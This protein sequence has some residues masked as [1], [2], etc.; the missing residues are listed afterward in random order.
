MFARVKLPGSGTYN[1]L[2]INDSAVGTDQSVKYVLFVGKD[3]KVEYRPVKLGPIVD[4]LRVAPVI[5]VAWPG[6]TA[7]RVFRGVTYNIR[8]ARAGESRTP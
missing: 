6:F 3:N 1:A 4:G 8:V 5:P 2:L 7:R